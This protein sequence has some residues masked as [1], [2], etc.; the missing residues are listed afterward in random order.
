MKV[1][2]VVSGL[3]PQNVRAIFENEAASTFVR[4]LGDDQG[5]EKQA[6]VLLAG[7]SSEDRSRAMVEA[8]ASLALAAVIRGAER[9][10]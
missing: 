3:D 2:R 7:R 8:S 6:E 9:P 5:L 4:R 1:S 10:G